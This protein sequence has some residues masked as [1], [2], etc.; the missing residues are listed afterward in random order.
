MS[1]YR[2]LRFTYEELYEESQNA[3]L[4]FHRPEFIIKTIGNTKIFICPVDIV[5]LFRVE[6]GVAKINLPKDAWYARETCP[7]GCNHF[8]WFVYSVDEI[9]LKIKYWVRHVYAILK[10][11]KV[12]F[13]L[14]RRKEGFRAPYI[15]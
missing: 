14:D 8:R 11:K 12:V 3:V 9:D 7:I 4:V 5:E 1:R 15:K 6:N 2:G 10:G 13:I